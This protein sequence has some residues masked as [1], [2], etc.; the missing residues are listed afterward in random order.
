MS[1]AWQFIQVS[2]PA[3]AWLVGSITLWQQ[4]RRRPRLI[5]G[6]VSVDT[7]RKDYRDDFAREMGGK[8]GTEALFVRLSIPL[9]NIGNAEARDVVVH[10]VVREI[11]DEHPDADEKVGRWVSWHAELHDSFFSRVPAD[12]AAGVT[13]EVYGHIAVP[14]G[15]HTLVRLELWATAQSG[16]SPGAVLWFRIAPSGTVEWTSTSVGAKV[17]R[18]A[19]ARSTERMGFEYTGRQGSSDP[20]WQA[21]ERR[22]YLKSLREDPKRYS[23]VPGGVEL[24]RTFR[25]VSYPSGFSL[26]WRRA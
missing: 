21:F 22:R 16:A 5:L 25:G 1:G 18:T 14:A 15:P 17:A 8:R 19:R 2:G 26:K 9:Q 11:L 7:A 3:V 12:S 10:P 24:R 23:I 6:E 20:L 13:A 4:V